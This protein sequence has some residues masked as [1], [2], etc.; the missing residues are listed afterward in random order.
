MIILILT[1]GKLSRD[2]ADRKALEWLN[3]YNGKEENPRGIISTSYSTNTNAAAPQSI[4]N[5]NTNSSQTPSNVNTNANTNTSQVTEG[6]TTNTSQTPPGSQ[7]KSTTT[8]AAGGTTSQ[9]APDTISIDPKV[10]Q[11]LNDQLRNIEARISHHGAV[12]AFFFK[13]YYMSISV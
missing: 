7:T 11:R 13:A 4:S 2:F 3:K 10:Q 5:A 8:A 9:S 12:M 6:A 1:I